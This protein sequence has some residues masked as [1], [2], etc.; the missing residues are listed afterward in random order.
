MVDVL[1]TF[2][3]WLA[4]ISTLMYWSYVNLRLQFGSTTRHIRSE[5]HWITAWVFSPIMFVDNTW[6]AVHDD[7]VG[8]TL[9]A[10]FMP[11]L[12]LIWWFVIVK[13]DTDDRWKKRRKKLASKVKQVAGKLV[14]VPVP[15]PS[16]A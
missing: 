4:F 5:I 11:I 2:W 6:Q 13:D 10:M 1:G 12:I 15:Q 14:V 16:G 9:Y 3:W 8:R 7:A